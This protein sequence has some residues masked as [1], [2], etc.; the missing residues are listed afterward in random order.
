MAA[1]GAGE[2]RDIDVMSSTNWNR[3]K[4]Q[5]VIRTILN[6]ACHVPE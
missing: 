2:A 3:S 5:L 1:G 6:E 4:V